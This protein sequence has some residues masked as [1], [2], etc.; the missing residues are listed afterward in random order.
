RRAATEYASLGCT[1]GCC[2]TPEGSVFGRGALA[3]GSTT[4]SSTRSH[5]A[6]EDKKCRL[7]SAMPPSPPN[8]SVTSAR[9]RNE[10]SAIA[11]SLRLPL[12]ERPNALPMHTCPRQVPELAANAGCGCPAAATLGWG[13]RTRSWDVQ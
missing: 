11:L 12:L 2:R 5:A 10:G 6:S 1:G 4:T 3:R 9:T 8:A 13:C 7:Y